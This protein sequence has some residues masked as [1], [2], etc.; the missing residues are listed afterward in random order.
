MKP[1]PKEALV[2]ATLHESEAWRVFK[3]VFMETRQMELA[4]AA[5]FLTE[6]DQ[7]LVTRGR[8][9]ELNYIEKQMTKLAEKDK[10]K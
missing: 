8:I 9:M 4:Q 2:L 7:I 6:M 1:T 3:K 10:K 5:P